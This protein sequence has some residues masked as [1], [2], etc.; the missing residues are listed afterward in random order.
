MDKKPSFL[1]VD[2]RVLPDTF[3]KVAKAKRK[4][5][6]GECKTATEAAAALNLS[7]STFYKYKD[8]IFTIH[9]PGSEQI[10]TLFFI[11]MDE[12]GVLSQILKV[13]AAVKTNVLTINQNIPI[14]DVANITISIRTMD[15]KCSMDDLLK[16]LKDIEYVKK[17][18]IIAES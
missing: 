12:P 8:S 16:K 4:L 11:L 5:E 15:M 2:T 7:R 6:S 1:L 18:E 14:G 10:V 13:L 9:R 17:V 3:I